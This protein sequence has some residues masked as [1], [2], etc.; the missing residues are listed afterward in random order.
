MKIS[1]I[2]AALGALALGLTGSFHFAA[3]K[4]A[5]IRNE[6][7]EFQQLAD[8]FQNDLAT[9]RQQAQTQQEALNKKT[10]ISDTV[11]PAVLADV[12]TLAEKS[13]NVRLRDLLAKY[14]VRVSTQAVAAPATSAVPVAQPSAQPVGQQAV[15]A[16]KGGN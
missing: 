2:I 4:N 6:S 16:K 15:S 1:Y 11:G 12:M 8:K 14:G 7:F 9:R 5:R 10:A 3:V 13:G